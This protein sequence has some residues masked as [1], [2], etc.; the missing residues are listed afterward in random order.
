MKDRPLY[1]KIKNLW[2]INIHCITSFS[3]KLHIFFVSKSI[4]FGAANFVP[5][6]FNSFS[7]EFNNAI[8]QQYAKRCKSLSLETCLLSIDIKITKLLNRGQTVIAWRVYTIL[9]YK[10][11]FITFFL[12]F[13]INF[14]KFLYPKCWISLSTVWASGYKWYSNNENLFSL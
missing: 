14:F 13:S 5:I 3:S 9:L 4:A 12:V 6:T 10:V 1:S 2:F 8:F 7:I 11:F